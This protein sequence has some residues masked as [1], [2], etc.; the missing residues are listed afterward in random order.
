LAQLFIAESATRR[1][2]NFVDNW[3][4]NKFIIYNSYV[5][6]QLPLAI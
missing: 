1:M 4:E 5:V 6:F 3:S 2:L